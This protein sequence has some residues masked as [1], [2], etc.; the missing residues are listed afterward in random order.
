MTK[1]CSFP[2][3]SRELIPTAKGARYLSKLHSWRPVPTFHSMAD[4][5]EQF[6]PLA[7]VRA[8]IRFAPDL[9]MV[10]MPVES[11]TRLVHFEQVLLRVHCRSGLH[12]IVQIFDCQIHCEF[13]SF[14]RAAAGYR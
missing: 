9:A 14:A 13:D 4:F 3:F 1:R 5:S 11:A 8:L 6:R 7:F 10:L 2:K 12:S